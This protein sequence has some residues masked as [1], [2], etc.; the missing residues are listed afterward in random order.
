MSR[1]LSCRVGSSCMRLVCSSS[2]DFIGKN[3]PSS[4]I[5][6]GDTDGM[7]GLVTI[8][9]AV[10]NINSSIFGKGTGSHPLVGSM[11]GF[12]GLYASTPRLELPGWGVLCFHSSV[13]TASDSFQPASQS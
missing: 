4:G 6:L 12:L 10:Y 8:G 2:K 9:V 5:A 3:V 7:G 1:A 11:D 13:A